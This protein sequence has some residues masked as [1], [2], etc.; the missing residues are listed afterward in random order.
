MNNRQLRNWVF[1]L[2]PDNPKHS[3][4]IDVIDLLPNS[5][6]IK[7]LAMSDEE[8]N[9]AHKEHF[10]CLLRYD[11][12]YWLSKL[13]GDLGLDEE[14]A[15]LF[16]SYRD[17]KIGNRFRFKTLNDYVLY[18]D[19]MDDDAKEDKYTPDDFHGSL[20]SWALEI[21]ASRDKDNYEM[22]YDMCDFI[23]SYHLDHF[24]DARTYTFNDWFK[25]CIDH[26][27]GKLFYNNWFKMRD[28]LRP[29]MYY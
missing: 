9:H 28:I 19:H 25:I 26:G 13:L 24:M 21:L 1:I 10:H 12:P 2:Y 22:F 6:Y 7:H 11:Q 27:Y 4:A 23:R 15:H 16:H 3:A 29:Y 20:R 8:G 17:F 14:D 5:L 18:L